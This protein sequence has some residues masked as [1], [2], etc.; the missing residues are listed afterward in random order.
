MVYQNEFGWLSVNYELEYRYQG[1]VT[2]DKLKYLRKIIAINSTDALHLDMGIKNYNGANFRIEKAYLES[3]NDNDFLINSDENKISWQMFGLKSSLDIENEGSSKKVFDDLF[4]NTLVPTTEHEKLLVRM[5]QVYDFIK[6]A[7][8]AISHE[9]IYTIYKML[10]MDI[11]MGNNKLDDG[12]IYRSGDGVIGDKFSTLTPSKV[13]E[14]MDDL[15]NSFEVS[16][17]KLVNAIVL[18]N[19]FVYIHPYYDY[20]GKMSRIML[21]WYLINNDMEKRAQIIIAS[22]LFFRDQYFMVLREQREKERNNFTPLAMFVT[23]VAMILTTA[24]NKIL[25]HCKKNGIKLS[26][27]ELYTALY[28]GSMEGFTGTKDIVEKTNLQISKGGVS[29]IFIN[30]VESGILETRTSKKQNMYKFKL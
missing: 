17:S 26:D 21:Y 23:D 29:K 20:N 12:H 10:T 18:M 14:Y 6:M 3:I 22:L 9:N 16:D 7:K 19:Q 25:D 4:S 30:L 13:H 2:M 11:D 1:G 24:M 27:S 28:V 8:P 15:I 5:K